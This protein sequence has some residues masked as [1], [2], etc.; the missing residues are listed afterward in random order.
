M[1]FVLNSLESKNDINLPVDSN[2]VDRAGKMRVYDVQI[3]GTNWKP[4]I[5]NEEEVF[6]YIRRNWAKFFFYNRNGNCNYV[7]FNENSIL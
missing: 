1:F 2:W 5:P 7:L 6:K 3:C 4:D